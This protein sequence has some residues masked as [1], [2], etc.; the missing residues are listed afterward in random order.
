MMLMRL[1]DDFLYTNICRDS[2][3]S[4]LKVEAMQMNTDN[5]NLYE[6]VD[7]GKR[8][9]NHQNCLTVDLY[10]AMCSN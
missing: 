2:P 5:I 7:K 1:F 8:A 10:R 6:D 9:V 3:E 4:P